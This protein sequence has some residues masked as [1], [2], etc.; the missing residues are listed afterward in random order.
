MPNVDQ[1]ERDYKVLL[2]GLADDE[3]SLIDSSLESLHELQ[4]TN[5]P[6]LFSK[7]LNS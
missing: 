4:T 1:F 7:A 6:T 5:K 2:K 3:N